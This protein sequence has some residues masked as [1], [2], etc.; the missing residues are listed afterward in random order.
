MPP[1]RPMPA[2]V[3]ATLVLKAD[4]PVNPPATPEETLQT[5]VRLLRSDPQLRQ[6]GPGFRLEVASAALDAPK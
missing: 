1:T 3:P 6:L 4:I 2:T 5:L